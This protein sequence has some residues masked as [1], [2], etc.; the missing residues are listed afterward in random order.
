MTKPAIA[1]ALAAWICHARVLIAP[2]VAVPLP[3][4]L[5]ALIGAAAAV[6]AAVFVRNIR[7]DG[8][9]LYPLPRPACSLGAPAL[10]T[11]K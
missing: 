11:G 7:R 4:V 10:S 1:V 8:W 2:G 3:A 6:L 9:Q 5:L